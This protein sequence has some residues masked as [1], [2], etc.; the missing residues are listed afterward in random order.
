MSCRDVADEN[1]REPSGSCPSASCTSSHL[2][3][4]SAQELMPPAGLVLSLATG[5]IVR[6][7]PST[8]ACGVATLPPCVA[9]EC[10]SLLERIPRLASSR[11]EM[12]SYH[13]C[14]L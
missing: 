5:A 2:A 7:R 9:A 10:R 8:S 6:T 4:S 13:D 3:M 14:P 1:S 11:D 12:E